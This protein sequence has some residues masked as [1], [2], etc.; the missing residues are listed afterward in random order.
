MYADVDKPMLLAEDEIIVANDEDVEEITYQIFS[1]HIK[2]LEELA[3][4]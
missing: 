2:A 4:K 1:R 3:T